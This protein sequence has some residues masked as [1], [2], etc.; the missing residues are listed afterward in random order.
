M[1]E[2]NVI[3]DYD[4]FFCPIVTQIHIGPIFHKTYLLNILTQ[5]LHFSDT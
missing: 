3:T 2:I 4:Q 5:K 1:G